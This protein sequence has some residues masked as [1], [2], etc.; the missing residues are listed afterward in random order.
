MPSGK[1]RERE[2]FGHIAGGSQWHIVHWTLLYE[3]VVDPQVGKEGG[4]AG[5]RAGK[6]EEG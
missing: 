4:R 3:V 5:G 6:R 2:G 1:W